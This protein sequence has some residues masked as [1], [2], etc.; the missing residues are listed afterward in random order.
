MSSPMSLP[1]VFISFCWIPGCGFLESLT[2]CTSVFLVWFRR[3]GSVLDTDTW[4]E[5]S[6]IG[7]VFDSTSLL[8]LHSGIWVFI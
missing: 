1:I 8:C 7:D 6:F 5:V 4:D 2:L 3:I